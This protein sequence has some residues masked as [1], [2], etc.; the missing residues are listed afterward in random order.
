METFFFAV[1]IRIIWDNWQKFCGEQDDPGDSIDFTIPQ[2][3]GGGNVLEA[4]LSDYLGWPLNVTFDQLDGS[5][6]WHRAYNLIYNE[7]FRDQNL[8]DSVVVD[9]DNGPDTPADYVVLSRGKRHDYFT[10]CLVAPQK[11]ASG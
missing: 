9:K 11:D 4:S 7:W 2:L 1:P 5:A 8:Q 10:S 3:A 6:L